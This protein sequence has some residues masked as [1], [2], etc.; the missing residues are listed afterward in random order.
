MSQNVEVD[1]RRSCARR[2]LCAQTLVAVF[3]P[4]L[5]YTPPHELSARRESLNTFGPDYGEPLRIVA[6]VN[7]QDTFDLSCMSGLGKVRHIE[8]PEL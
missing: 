4:K 1:T 3:R 2:A 5:S 6:W 8:T 7:A